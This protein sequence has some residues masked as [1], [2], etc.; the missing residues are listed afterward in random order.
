MRFYNSYTTCQ[1]PRNLSRL[2][3]VCLG[4]ALAC[5]ACTPAAD[6]PLANLRVAAQG[7]YAGAIDTS[8]EQ[9]LVGSLNHGASLW[10]LS[11]GERVFD[12]R[13]SA[14]DY[15]EIVAAAFSDNGRFV[16]TTEPR[17][18]ILWDALTGE[19]LGYWGSPGAILD[20]AALPDGRTVLIGM[21]DHSALL[22]DAV[23]GGYL[24]TLQH[25]GSVYCVTIDR[26]AQ[27]AL[28]ASE[29]H[30]AALWS[31]PDG[32]LLHRLQADN[33]V[34]QAALA[35]D[36]S[37]A[38]TAT[39]AGT[40]VLWDAHSGTLQHQLDINRRGVTRARFVADDRQLL[41]GYA[42]GEI[43]IWNTATGKLLRELTVP[44]RNPYRATG[45]AI[46]AL[47]YDSNKRRVLAMVGDGQLVSFAAL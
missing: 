12:W 34:R 15:A 7:I 2:N 35:S 22:F 10:R 26:D 5:S 40:L 6:R 8:G 1:W 24:A 23:D 45:N 30:T 31:L 21:D 20:A 47:G 4:L 19:A 37:L 9:A 36:A 42:N 29:D 43:E 16:V 28:T 41:V 27:V 3:A 33:P 32:T 46:A 13:H 25:E 44:L 39:Q 14:D 38:F 18:L 11:D 17:N